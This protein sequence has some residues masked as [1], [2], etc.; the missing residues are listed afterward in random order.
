MK[1][2]LI[3]FLSLVITILCPLSAMAAPHIVIDG[4]TIMGL[5]P[6]VVQSGSPLVPMRGVCEHLG[7]RVEWDGSDQSI[8][9]VGNGNRIVIT[10]GQTTAWLNGNAVTLSAPPQVTNG[11]TM[12]PLRVVGEALGANV[13]W[14]S[15]TKSVTINNSRNQR[16]S[17]KD[18]TFE[19]SF[20]SPNRWSGQFGQQTSDGGYLIVGSTN[21]E[22]YN[23]GERSHPPNTGILIWKMNRS[24]EFEWKMKYGDSGWNLARDLKTTGDGGFVL[25]AYVPATQ[26][27]HQRA[28]IKFNKT[29]DQEWISVLDTSI[30]DIKQIEIT[31]DGGYIITGITLHNNPYIDKLDSKG[32]AKWDLTL[33]ASLPEYDRLMDLNETS[34]GSFRFLFNETLFGQGQFISGHYTQAHDIAIQSID[35]Y[36]KVL[37]KKSFN[38]P[39]DVYTTGVISTSDGGYILQ[40]SVDEKNNKGQAVIL[41][42]DNEGRTIW[43]QVLNEKGDIIR[44]VRESSD[45]G[46]I[47]VG[48]VQSFGPGLTNGH[49]V[50]LDKSGRIAW[51]K[52]IG[53]SKNEL[54][55][56]VEQTSDGGYLS[57]GD[58]CYTDLGVYI[59][60]TD[61]NGDLYYR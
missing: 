48:Q 19:E 40:G 29:G 25:A 3:A 46:Y 61:A 54:F 12:V 18:S 53:T 37:D 16:L 50:K 38:Y 44:S 27:A 24:G 43:K 26:V 14:D 17:L 45:G 32:K 15:K 36:G 47:A 34:D 57:V 30:I 23:P 1:R 55:S 21:N 2:I 39:P 11:V 4:R 35:A 52:A 51:Q 28:V 8:T 31:R 33:D 41:K 7:A 9:A 10:I 56:S 13:K 58:T 20:E 60:K 42:T 22:L 5:P 6:V 59:L 49:L